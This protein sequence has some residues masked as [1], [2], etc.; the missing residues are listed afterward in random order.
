MM[1]R[2]TTQTKP[3]LRPTPCV[4]ETPGELKPRAGNITNRQHNGVS[5][6]GRTYQEHATRQTKKREDR[7]SSAPYLYQPSASRLALYISF[8][9]LKEYAHTSTPRSYRL[10]ASG[11]QPPLPWKGPP[12][13]A[14]QRLNIN[15]H[16][17]CPPPPPPPV[18][19]FHLDETTGTHP[20]RLL[21]GRPYR[22]TDR[23]SQ[24]HVRLP[25]VRTPTMNPPRVQSAH[26]HANI[27]NKK[28]S[29]SLS[30][31]NPLD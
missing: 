20:R 9:V 5:I 25:P 8:A 26:I 4:H 31:T 22:T 3:C 15:R 2:V 28:T 13:E 18:S 21:V 14:R 27:M 23:T 24:P 12:R 19:I 10:S 11:V 17:M 29:K 7:A 1:A 16:A 6:P 30:R